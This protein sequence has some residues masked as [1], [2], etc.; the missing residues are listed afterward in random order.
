MNNLDAQIVFTESFNELLGEG[1]TVFQSLK[2]LS[3]SKLSN[4]RIKR[5]SSYMADEIGKGSSLSSVFQKC[6][7]ISFDKI[8][9]WK[10]SINKKIKENI[11]SK[12][13]Y[14]GWYFSN[15]N[16]INIFII[17]YSI[18]FRISSSK[19]LI[20]WNLSSVLISSAVHS[21]LKPLNLPSLTSC[22]TSSFRTL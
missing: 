13:T 10:C 6:P 5:T 19:A 1:F 2:I 8:F 18:S 15:I 11:Y 20:D 14:D 4:K 9:R 7:Y 3:E 22:H 16:S 12:F 17:F 21:T